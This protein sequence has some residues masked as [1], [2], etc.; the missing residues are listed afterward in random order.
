MPRNPTFAYEGPGT[1]SIPVGLVL[2]AGG[3]IATRGTFGRK[4]KTSGDAADPLAMS[5][6]SAWFSL[7]F[8]MDPNDIE[9][10]VPD[11]EGAGLTASEKW[12]VINAQRFHGATTYWD[13]V[14]AVLSDIP[15][16]VAGTPDFS[17]ADFN[18]AGGDFA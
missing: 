10:V 14:A 5:G 4:P 16:G 8:D 1:L 12:R 17:P 18:V 3:R 13:T 6:T 11:V 7:P 2:H 9:F 15:E